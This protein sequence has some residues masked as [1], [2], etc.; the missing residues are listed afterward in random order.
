MSLK[1]DKILQNEFKPTYVSFSEIFFTNSK[2]FILV[3]FCGTLN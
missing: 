3:Q 2:R 1:I